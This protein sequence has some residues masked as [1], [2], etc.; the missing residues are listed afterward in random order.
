MLFRSESSLKRVFSKSQFES[1]RSSL[2]SAYRLKA[3]LAPS[4]DP[5][6][7]SS[8]LTSLIAEYR[9]LFEGLASHALVT[10]WNASAEGSRYVFA[11]RFSSQI[12]T[13][14]FRFALAELLITQD[15]SAVIDLQG[16]FVDAHDNNKSE[17][18]LIGMNFAGMSHLI[19]KLKAT[20]LPDGSGRSF[21]DV[22]T[23]AMYT[24]WD[25]HLY[26]SDHDGLTGTGPGTGH[27]ITCSAIMAGAGV[28]TG[29]VVG[30]LL[31]SQSTHPTHASL[32]GALTDPWSGHPFSDRW[33]LGAGLPIDTSTGVPDP[34]GSFPYIESMFPTMVQLLG[35]TM[36]SQQITTHAAIPAL[37][38]S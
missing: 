37:I 13:L 18:A 20:A 16:L 21:L 31:H 4:S 30:G 23:L 36:P 33:N 11:S 34:N 15:L 10:D 19:E 24:E 22:T 29:R 25:R 32:F 12:A 28:A 2:A 9:S 38:R 6:S 1:F 27:G 35:L 17:R 7:L 5:A 26:L 3:L 14:A 8:Q